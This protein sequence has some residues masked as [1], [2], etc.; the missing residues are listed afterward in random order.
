MATVDLF[1]IGNALIDQEFKVTD[2]FLGEAGLQKGTMQLTDGETQ[3]ALYEKLQATQD[4]KGQASGGSAANTTVAFSSLGGSAFYGCRVGNDELGAI[5][6][7]GLNDADIV[8]SEKSLTTGTT[9]TCMVLIS[10]DTERTMHTYLGITTEL[11]EQQIDYTSLKTA[12]WLYIEGYLSTSPTARQAVKQA[13]KIA[14]EHGVKIALSLSDPAMVQYAREGLDEMIDDGVDVLFCNEQEALMYTETQTL[15]EAFSRLKQKN[16]TVVVTQSAKGASV[17]NPHTHFHL[18]GRR[19][20]AIDAN[21]AGDAFA[22][23][24]LFA[25]NHGMSLEDATQLSILISS[26]VVSQ[27]GPRLAVESYATLLRNFLTE[28]A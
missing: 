2:Q 11:S 24:F 5:Y 23:A 28:C 4:Y 9:G 20:T 13:R 14:R 18:S 8:T 22:G 7:N 10:P 3:A 12:Q 15:D 16:H 21:G 27:Y 25:L 6:L 19:V 17:S 1:A 26:E